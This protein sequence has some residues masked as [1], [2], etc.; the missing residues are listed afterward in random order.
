M[1]KNPDTDHEMNMA[2]GKY[3]Q[4]LFKSEHQIKDKY[5]EETSIARVG[6]LDYC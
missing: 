6:V 3:T 5:G 4:E 1:L 2:N